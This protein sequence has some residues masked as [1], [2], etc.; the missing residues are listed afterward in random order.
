MQCR[1]YN[2]R[3]RTPGRSRVVSK[4]AFALC[5]IAL[6]VSVRADDS[7]ELEFFEKRIRPVLAGHCYQC[8]SSISPEAKG[9][10]RLD[11]RAGILKGGESGPAVV[12]GDSADSLLLSALK[13]ESFEMPP[14]KRLPDSVIRDF[15]QW[16]R[17]GAIDPRDTPAKPAALAEEIREAEFQQ[18]SDQPCSSHNISILLGA[19]GIGRCSG[20]CGSAEPS[21]QAGGGAARVPEAR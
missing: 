18:R 8:H 20:S 15:S 3:Y 10:L 16:I 21:I 14:G 17:Q 2:S 6:S 5:A 13:H 1:F 12:P 19:A 11:T 7:A 9:K 4:L